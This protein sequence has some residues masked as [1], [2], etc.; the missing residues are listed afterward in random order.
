MKEL[1]LYKLEKNVSKF[2]SQCK[3][4]Q[5]STRPLN[6]HVLLFNEENDL[7][8]LTLATTCHQLTANRGFFYSGLPNV[9]EDHQNEMRSL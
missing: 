7:N 8:L 2:N 3:P 1:Y 6:V 9:A 5:T 4:Q